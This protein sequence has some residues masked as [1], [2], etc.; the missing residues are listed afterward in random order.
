M[1]YDELINDY[2]IT[3]KCSQK[4]DNQKIEL[5]KYLIVLTMNI[6]RHLFIVLNVMMIYAKIVIMSIYYLNKILSIL[7]SIIQKKNFAKFI[8]IK[9]LLIFAK[10]VIKVYAHNVLKIYI[11]PI[12]IDGWI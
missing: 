11:I 6:A 8:K 3:Y 10:N 5:K 4:D 1:E 2:I 9:K 7:P 12:V